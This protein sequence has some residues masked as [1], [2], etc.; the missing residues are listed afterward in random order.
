MAPA[1]IYAIGRSCLDS[2][3]RSFLPCMCQLGRAFSLFDHESC[4]PHCV[5]MVVLATCT[6]MDRSCRAA[7]D[8]IVLASAPITGGSCPPFA[9][10]VVPA[11]RILVDRTFPIALGLGR[12]CPI[13]HVSRSRLASSTRSHLP[14]LS[15]TD[16][17][18]VCLLVS[19]SCRVGVSLVAAAPSGTVGC[20]YRWS[21][22]VLTPAFWWLTGLY[23]PSSRC[24]VAPALHAFP[25]RTFRSITC[26]VAPAYDLSTGRACLSSPAVAPAMLVG[27]RGPSWIVLPCHSRLPCIFRVVAPALRFLKRSCLLSLLLQVT[28]ASYHCVTSR[29]FFLMNPV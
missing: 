13:I 21:Q 10:V 18:A 17:L 24:S 11:F 4:L 23:L 29:S 2:H 12:P 5:S 20:S 6:L 22:V 28:P 14:C 9:H 15:S 7:T 8:T 1:F 25:D 26:V 27:G 16:V 3:A 19:R